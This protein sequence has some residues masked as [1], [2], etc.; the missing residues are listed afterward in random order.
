M[1]STDVLRNFKKYLTKYEQ[2][3]IKDYKQVWYIG[4]QAKKI[5]SSQTRQSNSGYDTKEGIY[6]ALINDH[7][8]YRYQIL[9]VLGQGFSGQILKCMDHKP[10]HLVAIK[11]IRNKDIVH[12]LAMPEKDILKALQQ[13]DKDNSA[14]TVHMKEK[15]Y[16]RSHLC[17]IF[18][19]FLTDQHGLNHTNESEF[20]EEELKKYTMDMLKCLQLLKEKIV[21][22]DLNLKMSPMKGKRT[23]LNPKTNAKN[24]VRPFKPTVLLS[25][26]QCSQKTQTDLSHKQQSALPGGKQK[27]PLGP[28]SHSPTVMKPI[29]TCLQTTQSVSGTSSAIKPAMSPEYVLE[30]FK[31]Y[32]TKYEQKEIKDYTQVWYIGKQAKKIDASQIR[33]SNSGY[34]TKEGIYSAIINDH[35]AY[36]YQILEVLGQGYSGQILKCMDHKTNQLV[37]IKVIRNKDIIYQTVL[38]EVKI[39]EALREFD[40]DNSANIVHMKEKFYF[41]SHL[42]IIFDLFL[43]D[44]H[45]LCH[46]NKVKVTEEEQK[47]YTMEILKCLQLLKETKIVHGDLKPENVLIYKKDDEMHTAVTDFGGSYFMNED[48]R[49][50]LFTKEYMSPELLLGKK[51]GPATDMWSLGCTIAELHCGFRLFHGC[52]L[53]YVFNRIMEVLGVPPPELLRAAPK[54][55]FF[56]DSN[57]IPYMRHCRTTLETKLNSIDVHFINFIERC[58]EY[59]PKKRMTPKQASQHPWI[60]DKLKCATRAGKTI[61]N[62]SVSSSN[63]SALL[64][65]KKISPPQPQK[66]LLLSYSHPSCVKPAP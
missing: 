24:R 31:E 47:K 36:R 26:A 17:I 4:K 23:V 61:S 12:D 5:D 20:T 52:D 7:L 6:R 14:N 66:A 62:A 45:A 3:E 16:F 48:D 42:C 15:F 58:L 32:L 63:T 27:C 28:S 35:L 41:R 50:R 39:L 33:P 8:G 19:L 60:H 37:A 18:D 25:I 9:E 22:G 34:D 64:K 51:C 2:K 54:R 13:F 53:P 38:P 21:H 65:R 10:M 29:V 56:F 1:I 30:H 46:T 44:L 43:K 11:V 57:G 55:K 59:D 49:P 40:K